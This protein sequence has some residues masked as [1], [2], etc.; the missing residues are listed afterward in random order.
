MPEVEIVHWNPKRPVI[1][2]PLGKFLPKKLVNNFGDVLGPIVVAKVLENLGV[3]SSAA[4]SKSRLLTIGSILHL[5]HPGDV[6]W[7]SGVNGKALDQFTP[8]KLDVRAVRGPLSRN[9]LLKKGIAVPEIFGDPGLLVGHFW[10]RDVLARGQSARD[11][12]EIPNFH[13]FSESTIEDHHVNPRGELWD[14]LR[15]IASS[16][17]V[18]GSSLHAIIVAESLGIP[19]RVI[20]SGTEPMFKYDDYFRGTGRAGAEPAS[21]FAEAIKMGGQ[22]PSIWSADQLLGAFPRDLCTPSL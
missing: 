17:F 15:Q 18:A 12:I 13:D 22:V 20:R 1:A 21:N 7:G 2:G 19:A 16:S 6:V 10:N 11:F 5:S 14:V 9:F 4:E 8:S 3:S